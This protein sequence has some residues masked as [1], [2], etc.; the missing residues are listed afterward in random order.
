M[1]LPPIPPRRELAEVAPLAVLRINVPHAVHNPHSEPRV[2]ATF[3]F[4]N[5][6][7]HLFN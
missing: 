7:E 1:P 5:D 6:I 3:R 2:V 4:R